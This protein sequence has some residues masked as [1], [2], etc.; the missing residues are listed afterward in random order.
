MARSKRFNEIFEECLERVFNGEPLEEC[1]SRFPEQADELRSLLETAIAARRAAAVEPSPEFRERVRQQLLNTMREKSPAKVE[2]RSRFTWNW[3][4]RWAVAVAAVLT[5]L[6]AGSSTVLASNNSMPGQ[7][8]YLVKQVSEQA[9][10]ALTFS[11]SA[12]A[13]VYSG[14]AERRVS[15]IVYLANEDNP[16]QMQQV[17]R[18]LESYFTEIAELSGGIDV[19]T[20]LSVR[21]GTDT[22]GQPSD[23]SSSRDLQTEESKFTVPGTTQ[24]VN[25][26]TP[27]ETLA[28]PVSSAP[29]PFA[30]S[31]GSGSAETAGGIT[32]GNWTVVVATDISA[33]KLKARVYYQAI[34]YP[35]RLKAALANTR[36]EVRLALLH[37]I[38]VSETGYEKVLQSLE[39]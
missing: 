4:P 11:P 39:N 32:P 24:T 25:T 14:L 7:P 6:V 3:Q 1:V 8:L 30:V 37:A 17:T 18:E 19:T 13:E 28:A 26:E 9:R 33:A 29:P 16:E 12:K 27:P 34:E 20:V 10:L 38:A 35:A 5:L 36:P 22:G 2:K 31:E 23:S 21:N 15:E